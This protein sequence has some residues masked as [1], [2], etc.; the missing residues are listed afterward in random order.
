MSTP[1]PPHRRAAGLPDAR[2]LAF[3]FRPA[4]SRVAGREP[5][6]PPA[7]GQGRGLLWS[8][9]AHEPFGPGVVPRAGPAPLEMIVARV[10]FGIRA[11]STQDP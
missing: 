1:A 10:P 8:G 9:P 3:R 6:G 4:R 5:S 2:L 11:G 7:R